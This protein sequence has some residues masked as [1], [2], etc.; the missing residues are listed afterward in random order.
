MLEG[1]ELEDLAEIADSLPG[2]H[3]W[4][5]GTADIFYCQACYTAFEFGADPVPDGACEPL[6][7]PATEPLLA[8]LPLTEFIARYGR[9]EANR[10]L[11]EAGMQ[12]G[13]AFDEEQQ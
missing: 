6:D 5:H 11:A 9:A 7:M 12:L 2:P 3:A 8:G 1:F 13:P 4:A 10:R